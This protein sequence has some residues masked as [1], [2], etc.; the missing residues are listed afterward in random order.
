MAAAGEYTIADLAE[1]F[2]I[3]RAPVYRIIRRAPAAGTGKA[4]WQD[5]PVGVDG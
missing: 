3:C 1:V 4:S 2:T 5:R